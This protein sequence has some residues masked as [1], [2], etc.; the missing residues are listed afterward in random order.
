MG[1]SLVQARFVSV[2]NLRI[3]ERAGGPTLRER[4]G[5]A[6]VALH[7]S[8]AGTAES[9]RRARANARNFFLTQEN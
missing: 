6:Y 4:G 5:G 2:S 3:D 1:S 8:I 9:W 7:A